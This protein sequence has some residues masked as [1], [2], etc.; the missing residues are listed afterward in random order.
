MTPDP[1]A[2]DKDALATKGLKLMED[3]KVTSL[4]IKTSQG[5]VAGIIHLHDLW[6][7]EMF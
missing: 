3:N 2:I 1:L 6:R 7:T 5:T 4:I